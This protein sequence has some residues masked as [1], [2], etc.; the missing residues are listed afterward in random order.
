MDPSPP[1]RTELSRLWLALSLRGVQ[2]IKWKGTSRGRWSPLGT[3]FSQRSACLPRSA[4]CSQTPAKFRDSSHPPGLPPSLT[5]SPGAGPAA[6]AAA[7]AAR[8]LGC[9]RTRERALWRGVGTE[10]NVAARN[11]AA[12]LPP[13]PPG[14][15]PAPA[16]LW[17]STLQPPPDSSRKARAG[18]WPWA[19]AHLTAPPLLAPSAGGGG[20]LGRG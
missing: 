18:P 10:G 11:L 17:L 19:R 9:S 13:P 1:E 6:L 8:A 2:E 7:A 4:S 3:G 12:T 14:T 5:R 16:S 20:Y 15:T